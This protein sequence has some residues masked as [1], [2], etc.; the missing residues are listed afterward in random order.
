[1]WNK[2]HSRTTNV[3]LSPFMPQFAVGLFEMLARKWFAVILKQHT[4]DSKLLS[5]RKLLIAT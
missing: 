2:H 5:F 4:E 3:E 1:M